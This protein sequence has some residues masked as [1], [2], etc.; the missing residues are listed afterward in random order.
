MQSHMVII[1]K[2]FLDHVHAPILADW[3]AGIAR[4]RGWRSIKKL[5]RCRTV[6]MPDPCSD[7]SG[8]L[9]VHRVHRNRRITVFLPIRV[10]GDAPTFLASIIGADFPVP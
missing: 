10:V 3:S 5:P 9:E 2:A 1:L 6:E 8:R 4:H 7:E